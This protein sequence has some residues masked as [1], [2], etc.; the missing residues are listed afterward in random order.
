LSKCYYNKGVA[1]RFLKDYV[2]AE[3][4]F[5]KDNI[6]CRKHNLTD[7]LNKNKSEMVKLYVLTNQYDKALQYVDSS[8]QSKMK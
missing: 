1:Y 5:K 3:K 8:D 7:E 6:Y 2:Q 4:Y